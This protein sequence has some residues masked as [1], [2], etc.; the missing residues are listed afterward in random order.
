[1]QTPLEGPEHAHA[2][3]RHSTVGPPCMDSGSVALVQVASG[4]S[5][6]NV[7]ITEKKSMRLI[8]KIGY[9]HVRIKRGE[10]ALVREG[11]AGEGRGR[12]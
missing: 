5:P 9:A 6:T 10:G 2:A 7:R 4:L 3:A 8:K 11:S 1:M 12:W